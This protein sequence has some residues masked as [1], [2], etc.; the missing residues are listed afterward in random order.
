[1]PTE[2]REHPPAGAPDAP[3][4]GVR[5][6]FRSRP[7]KV[8]SGAT[9]PASAHT[10]YAASELERG[11][12]L[13]ALLFLSGTILVVGRSAR[14]ALFLTR[15]P[16]TWIGPMWMAY[17][18][19]S[20]I[21][22]LAY[23]RFSDKLPKATFV[24]SFAALSAATYIVLRVLIGLELRPA[25][26]AFYV[27]SDVIANFTTVAIWSL[28]QDLYDAHAAKRVFGTIGMGQVLGAVA[29]GFGTGIVVG[30]IGTENLLLVIACSLLSVGWGASVLVRRHP[31]HPS[32]PPEDRL[33]RKHTV[34]EPVWK[35]PYVVVLGTTTA[36]LFVG[37]T[38]G[39]YQFKAIVR[40]AFPARDELAR[41]MANFYGVVGLASLALQLFV[42][43][44]LLRRF[45]VLAGLLAMPLAFATSTVGLLVS[46]GLAS[47]SLLKGS[48]NG[49][50]FTVHDST[51]QLLLF[52]FPDDQRDRVRTLVGALLKPLGCGLGALALML[53]APAMTSGA[54]IVHGAAALGRVT[55][56]IM[57]VV[58]AVTPVVRRRY[59][60]AMRR[61]LLR[62]DVTIDT[63]EPTPRTLE[64]LEEAVTDKE[65]P[66]ALF[67]M[68]R[69]REWAPDRLRLAVTSLSHHPDAGIRS[70]ALRTAWELDA[71][72]AVELAEKGSTDADAK[73]RVAAIQALGATLR[74]DA[75]D[76]LL[77]FADDPSDRAVRAAA[78]AALL[79]FCGLD[80]MLDGAPRLRALLESEN[81]SDR[82][83]AARV[84]GAVGEAS[85]QRSLARL[86]HD[87]DEGVRKAAIEAAS[88]V[89][90]S[91]LLPLF[92][93]ALAI[94][95][96]SSGASRAIV[97]LGDP[98]VGDVAKEL[99]AKAT[100]R[101]VRLIVPR[102]L[103]RIGTPAA[104]GALLAC[105]E[106]P[107]EV[108]RQKVLASAS[109]LRSV[110]DA[111]PLPI[112]LVRG[113][114]EA[115]LAEHA[116]LRDDFLAVRPVVTRP[117]LDAH[118]SD[119][120]R[121]GL[122]RIL[123]L[124]EL[125]HPREIVASARAHLFSRDARLRAN[126]LEVIESLL[127]RKL[128]ERLVMEVERFI[129]LRGGEA[130]SARSVPTQAEAALWLRR[131]VDALD[132]YR[133]ALALEA[134]RFHR[135]GAAADIAMR[136]LTHDSP[137]V[138]EAAILAVEATAPPGGAEAIAALTS[139]PDD[140]VAV[141]AR[142]FG[143]PPGLRADLERP[144]YSTIEKVLLLQRVPV[145]AKVSGDDLVALARVSPVVQMKSGDVIFREGEPG[146]A[147]YLILAGRVRLSLKARELSELTDNDVFGEMAI[148]DQEPRGVTATVTADTEL[149]R[150]SAEHFHEAVRESSEIAE[151]VIQVLNR[152]LREAD[153]RLANAQGGDAVVAA[154][155]PTIAVSEQSSA[156]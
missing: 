52:P 135:I 33:M 138:R 111:R 129:A 13:F 144:V 48:D 59:L 154:A 12:I 80:G 9:G 19:V 64:V 143:A 156:E 83:A 7:P 122:V 120:L 130:L 118:L 146:T 10:T 17:A 79:Q 50:Q 2:G 134:I 57:L 74:E 124:C 27:S 145:F 5:P 61:T 151:A 99:T 41:Y 87:A 69:L 71:T 95:S 40:S 73:V 39:D 67:A 30:L 91:R 37:L 44:V 106:E 3:A 114:I 22:A 86:L 38:V 72:D 119:R 54:S 70:L 34:S 11:A 16:V 89:R 62:R 53:L 29:S 75:H 110:L 4:S 46:P 103:L 148:F 45:G 82:V 113:R 56:P 140:I 24:T 14:D 115:E 112:E 25:I 96:L 104:L 94:P 125:V 147:M 150:V 97:A 131:E 1:M 47:A 101:A 49:L 136:Q 15:F 78:I 18:V 123:R 36:L 137:L 43:P 117:L 42:T 92:L 155:P 81:A 139:D 102:I 51:M 152:R 141:N 107:D 133:A 65:A 100:S 26:V 84:L 31:L 23:A 93:H 63:L 76:A 32:A 68:A 116:A 132:P 28:A 35:S 21:A 90:D 66:R 142:Y 153:R 109:R 128:R 58:I 77:R 149:L 88:A 108:I 85:L 127:D 126:A 8:A 20:S 6:P 98:V 121:K 55:L 105:L 60:E